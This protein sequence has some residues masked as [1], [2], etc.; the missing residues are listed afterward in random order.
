MADRHADAGTVEEA[1]GLASS[2]SVHLSGPCVDACDVL[3]NPAV[4]DGRPMGLKQPRTGAKLKRRRR[5]QSP[6]HGGKGRAEGECPRDAE[7]A[8][9]RTYSGCCFPHLQSRFPWSQLSL[10]MVQIYYMGNSRNKQHTSFS[11]R[12]I[13]ESVRNPHTLPVPPAQATN[14]PFVQHLLAVGCGPPVSPLGALW[15]VG[16]LLRHHRA[17]TLHHEAAFM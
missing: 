6:R 5:P 7:P 3:T 15:G 12:A 17:L 4:T 2:A 8:A 11:L 13:L 10:T 16:F 9:R 14:P 1:L